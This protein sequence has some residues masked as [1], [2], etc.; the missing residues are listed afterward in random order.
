MKKLALA[1][2]ACLVVSLTFVEVAN[3]ISPTRRKLIVTLPKEIEGFA[4]EEI[5]VSGKISSKGT[6]MRKVFVFV[7]D[8]PL[9]YVIEPDY[10][11]VIPFTKPGEFQLKIKIPDNIEEEKVYV[12]TIIAQETYT[13]YRT[14]GVATLKIRAKP[15]AEFSLSRIIVPQTIIENQSF[16]LNVT[17]ENKGSVEEEIKIYLKLPQ[18]W[19]Y[20]DGIKSLKLKPGEASTLTFNI[21]PSNITGSVSI[22]LEYPYKG[23]LAN[24]TKL[25]PILTP[26]SFKP[27]EEFPEEEITSYLAA[28]QEISPVLIV[29]NIIFL[30]IIAWNI[31]GMYKSKEI[32]KKE[33]TMKK[34]ETA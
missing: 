13:A 25:G 8:L 11:E 19:V 21:T 7:E 14:E 24:F 15:K 1:V 18:Q 2:I 27:E 34:G 28:I 30:I 16:P 26:I 6:W 23:E 10:F 29:L 32:R 31:Y 12:A 20:E 3:S 17:I 22:V 5:V 33:E 9:T 4:G